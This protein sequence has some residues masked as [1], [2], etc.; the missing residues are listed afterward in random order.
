MLPRRLSIFIALAAVVACGCRSNAPA[1][2]PPLA[3]VAFDQDRAFRD[4][5]AQ[6]A[7]GPRV[8]GAKAHEE[9]KNY[10]ISQ[11]KPYVDEVSTQ[12]F[13]FSDPHR[14]VVLPMTN[15]FGVI[16]GGGPHKVMLCAHWDTR[17]TA[18]NDFD[19]ANRNKPI[20]GADDGASGVATLL[21]LARG[22]HEQRPTDEVILAFWDGEDWGPGDDMM[23]IGARHFANTSSGSAL[24]PDE[25]VLID[26][27]GQKGL[28]IPEE[29]TSNARYPELCEKVWRTAARL[30]YAA[31]FPERVDYDITDDHIPLIEAGIPSI[32]LI[33][34]NYASW[35]TLDDTPDKCSPDSLGIVGRVLGAFVLQER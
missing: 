2:P 28:V 5:E 24:R 32:D 34:F 29:K 17:P 10:I 7:F 16:H 8:P 6:V 22:L 25:C 11:L 15:I 13:E 30:G 3:T 18:D 26:M 33:D 31:Q 12:D 23:Y 9:C 35:H 27:I 20:P 14:R 4:L 1:A 21:E 19:P